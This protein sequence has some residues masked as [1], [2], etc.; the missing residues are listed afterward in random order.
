MK[1]TFLKTFFAFSVFSA[2]FFLLSVNVL[3]QK[4]GNE[5]QNKEQLAS[6][7]YRERQWEKA[8]TLYLELYETKPQSFYYRYYFYCMT[9]LGEFA[10]LE[11]F[12]RDVIKKNPSNSLIY[13]V[14]LGYLYNLS[15]DSKKGNKKFEDVLSDLGKNPMQVPSVASEFHIYG[16]VKYAIRAYLKGREVN[17]DP[18]AYAL[19]LANMY[20]VEG[21]HQAMSEEYVNYTMA[22]P[23]QLT[24]IKNRLQSLLA[25][26]KDG[27]RKEALKRTFIRNAQKNSD[28]AELQDVLIWLAIQEKDFPL[29]YEWSV[30]LDKRLNDG[31]KAMMSLGDMALSNEDYETAFNA[32]QYVVNKGKTSDLYATAKVNALNARYHSIINKPNYKKSDLSA[33]EKDYL[34]L[35]DEFGKNKT[36]ILLIQNYAHLLAFYLDRKEEAITLLEEALTIP[37]TTQQQLAQIKMELADIFILTGD[38]WDAL[39]LYSQVDKAFKNNP[40]GY[41]AKFKTAKLSFYMGEFEW[42]N[43]QL[44]VLKAATDRMIANDAIELS[45]MISDNMEIDSTHEGLRFYAHADLLIAQHKYDEALVM[46]DNIPRLSILHSLNDDVLM[47]KAE[48]AMLQLDFLRADSL[49]AKFAIQFPTS[50]L[51]DN[52]LFM[53]AK[54]NDTKLKRPEVAKECYRQLITEYSGSIYTS[55]ARKELRMLRE[56]HLDLE[57]M[58]FNNSRPEFEHEPEY[59]YDE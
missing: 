57:M 49:L 3:A 58:F 23:D 19:D 7:Y 15:G 24:S 47:K 12:V 37:Q 52:A 41:E 27:S 25:N 30:S 8:A 6:Q 16:E 51:A 20:S 38:V 44:K 39:L 4:Q 48:I 11:K 43:A 53:R 1:Y 31:G 13:E 18:Y 32:Y 29:A 22:Y 54:L 45:L 26:D 34:S 50:I 2:L 55:V 40:I 28:R 21:N 5:Q 36:T 35:F 59:D 14:N 9:Q 56:E 42:A 10:K 17:K 33:V 46:L